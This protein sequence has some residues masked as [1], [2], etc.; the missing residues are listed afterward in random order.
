M[1][2]ELGGLSAAVRVAKREVG[3]P[4]DA[5]VVL[6]PHPARRS[7]AQELVDALN[8]SVVLAALPLDWPPFVERLDNWVTALRGGEPALVPPLVLDI[9]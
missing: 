8:A 1:V 9:R 3:L 7:L 5:D 2:D 6:V 4:E